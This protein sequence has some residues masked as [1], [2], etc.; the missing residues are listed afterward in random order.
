M[1]RKTIERKIE[2]GLIGGCGVGSQLTSEWVIE[3]ITF[4]GID[5]NEV[6]LICDCIH[7]EDLIV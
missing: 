6:T 2:F 1:R 3:K 7:V 5:E 4:F